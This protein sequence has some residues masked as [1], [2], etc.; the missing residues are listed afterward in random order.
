MVGA[1]EGQA[2]ALP[3]PF[4]DP[5]IV[6]GELKRILVQASNGD[7]TERACLVGADMVM[8]LGRKLKEA[9]YGF[10]HCACLLEKVEGNDR[11]YRRTSQV[12][13]VK[14]LIKSRIRQLQGRSQEDPMKVCISFI[15]PM[16]GLI[17]DFQEI[18]AL[19][20]IGNMH[21]NIMGQICCLRDEK[22]IYSVMRFCNG[23][24]LYDYVDARGQLSEAQSRNL[25]RQV[26]DGLE[27]L[28]NIGVCHR[29][30]SLENLMVT[31]DMECIII[32]MGMCLRLPRHSDT[33][34]VYLI[35]RQGPCGKRNYVSPEVLANENPFNGLLVDIWAAG[36]IL[37]ILLT[38][39]PPVDT[40]SPL[41]SRFRMI[42]DG[43]LR[44]MLRQW[45]IMIS[46]ESMDLLQ[47]ILVAEP[48]E[49]L[50]IQQIRDHPWMH[51]DEGG[52]E[53]GGG[54]MEA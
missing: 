2:I 5:I 15:S 36:V 31:R 45:N 24:E 27:H 51:M 4:P 11:L 6:D 13:A 10:V 40:A 52:D 12:L 34:D 18:A 14:I 9:I 35:P 39:V 28:Q 44:D 22:H 37:F 54:D 26:L 7:V 25:F 19:Q 20:F 38:G 41:D 3:L 53:G 17:L 29:D 47:K 8:E 30:M 49:R 46:E 16:W 32:D 1:H 21:P 48:S 43:G 42:R 23:G 50:T 33:D